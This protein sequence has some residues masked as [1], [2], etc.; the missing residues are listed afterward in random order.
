MML[1][2]IFGV[3][4]IF[5]SAFSRAKSYSAKKKGNESERRQYAI[6]GAGVDVALGVGIV[7]FG[8]EIY[9]RFMEGPRGSSVNPQAL[10][11]LWL[12][13]ILGYGLAALGGI[14]L[15]MEMSVRSPK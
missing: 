8:Q 1:V 12:V 5:M 2:V 13:P 3:L 11:D 14:T 6:I 7:L 9:I 10:S 15:L 4:L